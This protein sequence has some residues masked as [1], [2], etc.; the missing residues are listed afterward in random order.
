MPAM[1]LNAS[2]GTSAKAAWLSVSRATPI[3]GLLM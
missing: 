3:T 1:T 2:T